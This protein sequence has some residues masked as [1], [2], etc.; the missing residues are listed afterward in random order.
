M[1]SVTERCGTVAVEERRGGGGL[2]VVCCGVQW[3]TVERLGSRPWG[4]MEVVPCVSWH[5]CSAPGRQ[6]TDLPAG[7]VP[8]GAGGRARD[9][10]GAGALSV[11]VAGRRVRPFHRK[12]PQRAGDE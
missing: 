11:R 1:S 8:R 12:P 10:E 2:T 9:H 6:G 4:L 5:P 3:R 7:E